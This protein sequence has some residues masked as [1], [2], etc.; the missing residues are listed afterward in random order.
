MHQK[1][2]P[3]KI[4]V[5]VGPEN[6]RGKGAGRSFDSLWFPELPLHPAATRRTRRTPIHEPRRE[7]L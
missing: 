3:A 6:S 1:Q 2:P 4:A 7:E 5:S